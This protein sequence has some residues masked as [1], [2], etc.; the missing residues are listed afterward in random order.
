M[1]NK[2]AKKPDP[3]AEMFSAK[4]YT[5]SQLADFHTKIQRFWETPRTLADGQIAQKF[6]HQELHTAFG[7]CKKVQHGAGYVYLYNER[8]KVL[9]N[10]WKQYE[11]W[12]KKQDWIGG[13]EV[14]RLSGISEEIPF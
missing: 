3:L 8:H 4:E 6:N 14:E 1:I 7:A 11:E 13:K 9:T 12:R 2:H 5:E 10:L